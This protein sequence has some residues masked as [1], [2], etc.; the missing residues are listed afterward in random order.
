MARRK[1]ATTTL[2]LCGAANARCAASQGRIFLITREIKPDFADAEV[3]GGMESGE[4]W[5]SR[6]YDKYGVMQAMK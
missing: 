6:M 2:H 1:P 5:K 3:K 4:I